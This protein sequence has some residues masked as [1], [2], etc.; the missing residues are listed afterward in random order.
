[1][2][3]ITESPSGVPELLHQTVGHSLVE[4][5]I[6]N[7]LD[8]PAKGVTEQ[9]PAQVGG[10][11]TRVDAAFTAVGVAAAGRAATPGLQI[12]IGSVPGQRASHTYQSPAGDQVSRLHV[13]TKPD[14]PADLGRGIIEGR[15]PAGAAGEFEIG[16][17][18]RSAPARSTD[19]DVRL[20]HLGVIV[21]RADDEQV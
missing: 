5:Q 16:S 10:E 11:P 21:V 1:M 4:A 12:H 2:V 8:K 15:N 20:D 7:L 14:S 19:G 17:K 13:A 6:S 3:E 9:W 18:Q